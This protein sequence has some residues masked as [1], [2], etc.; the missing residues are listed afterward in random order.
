LNDNQICIFC[1]I[2]AGRA[3]AQRVYEDDRSLI[4][5][6]LFPAH[7]GHTLI[8]PKHHA[9]SLFETSTADLQRV[10]AHSKPLAEALRDVFKADGVAVMQ[11]NGEAA[12]QT[13][14]HYHM[15]LIPRLIG[16]PFG[17]HGKRMADEDVLADQA[18]RLSAVFVP[19]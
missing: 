14:F 13:V 10:I 11:L 9:P 18:K 19:A 12:G 2:V 1:E 7:P 16:E 8:I 15:H 5:M 3:T 6:D 4:F 17:V